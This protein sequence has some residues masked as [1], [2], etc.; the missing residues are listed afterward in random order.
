MATDIQRVLDLLEDQKKDFNGALA[1]FDTEHKILHTRISETNAGLQ[2]PNNGVHVRL[3]KAEGRL[4]AND[5]WHSSVEKIFIAL[6]ISILFA[7]GGQIAT[8][9]RADEPATVTEAA[10]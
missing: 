4:K 1:R 9:V 3:T 6:I 8:Y 7:V 5:K 2:E 10:P